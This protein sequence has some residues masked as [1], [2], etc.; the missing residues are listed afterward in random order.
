MKRPRI[1]LVTI[2]ACRM[3]GSGGNVRA[4]F[5]TRAAA[6]LGDLTVLSLCGATGQQFDQDL[7]KICDRV[8]SCES[9]RELERPPKKVSSALGLIATPWRH[10]WSSFVASCVQHCS[11]VPVA[12]EKDWRKRWLSQILDLEH[13]CLLQMGLLPPMACLTWFQE[14]R[15]LR[16]E[17]LR[18]EAER[19]FDVLWVEDVFSWPFAADLLPSLFAS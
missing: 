18:A 14:Y 4:H 6:N 15:N 3:P 10:N 7:Q 17:V 19:P 9:V 2:H 11:G 16:P 8:I 13:S 5:F 12:R 1:L